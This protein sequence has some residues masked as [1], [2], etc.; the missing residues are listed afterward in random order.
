MLG[1]SPKGVGRLLGQRRFLAN[2]AGLVE[3]AGLGL[4]HESGL[5]GGFTS[6][7]ALGA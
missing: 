5:S 1:G 3:V 6:L 2:R 7:N 4:G